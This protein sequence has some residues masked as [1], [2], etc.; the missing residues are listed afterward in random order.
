MRGRPNLQ[1]S[2]LAI[3]DSEE[4]VSLDRRLRRIVDEAD[5][6]LVRFAPVFDGMYA[7]VGR[8]SVPP[9]W[10]LK[11]SVLIALYSVRN[12]RTF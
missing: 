1:C 11:A 3:V 9:D 7:Q 10:L 2:M 12:E 6:A 8:V 5:A 4:Q